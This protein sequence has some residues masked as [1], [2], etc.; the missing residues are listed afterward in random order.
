MS[1][2]TSDLNENFNEAEE[3]V[4]QLV[5]EAMNQAFEVIDSK[6]LTLRSTRLYKQL[7]DLAL[8]EILH[9]YDMPQP[10]TDYSH[11][12]DAWKSDIPAIPSPRGSLDTP[13]FY[14]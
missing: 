1:Q 4:N 8:G 13:K 3:I 9:V 5:D 7:V 12:V 11:I 6:N 10:C 2:K 14:I